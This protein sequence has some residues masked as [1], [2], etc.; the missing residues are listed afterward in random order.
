MLTHCPLKIAICDDDQMDRTRI[1]E[2]TIEILKEADIAHSISVFETGN[3]LLNTI[4]SGTAFHVLLLDVMM[5]TLDGMELASILRRNRNKTAIIFISSNREMALR[6]YEVSAA[7]YLAK[8]IEREKLK[9]ALLHCWHTRPTKKE[10]LLPTAQGQQRISVSS[11]QFVE[12]FDRGS[13]FVLAEET[14]DARIKFSEAEAMLPR[15]SFLL[16]HRA[17]IVNIAHIRRIHAREFEMRNGARIPISKHRYDQVS[18]KFF[19]YIAD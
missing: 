19:E 10:I 5:D 17:Y 8:P 1:A 3:A 14:V 12:A 15:L 18:K 6:G 7:R 9:E 11:I 16:C 13:R 2:L 4:Q